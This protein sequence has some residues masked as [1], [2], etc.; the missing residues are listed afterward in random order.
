MNK[1]EL[2]QESTKSTSQFF[3]KLKDGEFQTNQW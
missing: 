2:Y 3:G 1:S